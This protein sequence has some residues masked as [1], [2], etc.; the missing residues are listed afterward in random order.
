MRLYGKT[1]NNA[2]SDKGWLFVERGTRKKRSTDASLGVA[3]FIEGNQAGNV[4]VSIPKGRT[5]DLRGSV[6]A[7]G[8][9]N[10]AVLI[11]L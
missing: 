3:L 7:S 10:G 1:E 8:G 9:K 2:Q 6:S 11:A 5:G 4:A